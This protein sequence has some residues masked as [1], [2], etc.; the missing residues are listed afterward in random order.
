MDGLFAVLGRK[1]KWIVFF[2]CLNQEE[3]PIQSEWSLLL[4]CLDWEEYSIYKS[5]KAPTWHYL[6][7]VT[8][9][10]GAVAPTYFWICVVGVLTGK[11]KKQNSLT[12]KF[13]DLGGGGTNRALLDF[14]WSFVLK[15]E[16]AQISIYVTA[17]TGMRIIAGRGDSGALGKPAPMGKRAAMGMEVPPPDEGSPKGGWQCWWWIPP[18]GGV[19]IRPWHGLMECEAGPTLLPPNGPTPLGFPSPGQTGNQK[20]LT[21][22]VMSRASPGNRLMT[23]TKGSHVT[24][25]YK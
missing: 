1:D 4:D 3:H 18:R 8:W 21:D 15:F 5:N 13:D 6:G 12:S 25:C 22:D 11:Q 2:S 16:A 24:I 10:H 19:D 14:L 23:S 7:T 9:N 20:H 17:V